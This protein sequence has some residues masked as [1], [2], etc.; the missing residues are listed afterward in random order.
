MYKEENEIVISYYNQ[1]V[2]HKL[3]DFITINPRIEEAWSSLTKFAPSK[4]ARILEIGCGIGGVTFRLNKRWPLAKITGIDISTLSIQ[5]ATKLF[6]NDNLKF[7]SGVLEPD[8]FEE[9]FDFIVLMD[10][11]EHIAYSAR[12]ELHAA[13]NKMLKNKGR[14]FL[15]VPTPHNLKWLSKHKPETIQPVDEYISFDIISKLAADTGTEV[16]LYEIKSVWNTGDYAHIVLEK[17]DDFESAF[18]TPKTITA[19]QRLKRIFNKG[20]Y[21]A[22][23]L[24]RKALVKNKLK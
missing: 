1:H 17:N 19:T 24:F 15:S 10:V 6:A 23:S 4:P 18:F 5:V 16:L 3:N 2:Q 20:R 14:I 21:K 22:G 8:T 12:Q 7:V 13:L 11:Y 9:Q